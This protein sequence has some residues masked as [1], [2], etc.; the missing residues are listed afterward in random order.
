ML[1]QL[2]QRGGLPLQSTPTFTEIGDKIIA[3]AL[4]GASND[5]RAEHFMVFTTHAG[6]IIDMQGFT[7]E[8]AAQRFA[9]A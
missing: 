5:Q 6:K 3:R 8:R 9:R 7:S 2:N 1:F 4:W